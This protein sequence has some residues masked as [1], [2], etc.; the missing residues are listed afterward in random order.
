MPSSIRSTFAYTNGSVPM[1]RDQALEVIAGKAKGVVDGTGVTQSHPIQVRL[2]NR[3]NS[4][5]AAPLTLEEAK[6]FSKQLRAAIEFSE[7]NTEVYAGNVMLTA[8]IQ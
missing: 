3:S 1:A 7:G 8:D 2:W 5:D 4:Y 6:E